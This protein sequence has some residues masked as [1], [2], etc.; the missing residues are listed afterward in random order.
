MQPAGTVA[1]DP[2]RTSGRGL[3]G[4]VADAFVAVARLA[5]QAATRLVREVPFVLRTAASAVAALLVALRARPV[6][7]SAADPLPSEV[8]TPEPTGAAPPRRPPPQHEIALPADPTAPRRARAL[9]RAAVVEWDLDDDVYEDAAM[10]LTEL[11]ANAVDH[12]ATASTV[13]LRLDDL[14][15]H[16]AVR[17]ARPGPPPRPYPLDPS[18]SR[19]RGLQMVDALAVAWGV[20]TQADGKIVWAVIG[21]T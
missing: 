9:L 17:D 18:A 16:L 12:A 21:R 2:G 20:T 10:V 3:A 19:G 6:P 5:G 7:P 15:L 13:T 1:L 11:V 8:A 14:G 4:L